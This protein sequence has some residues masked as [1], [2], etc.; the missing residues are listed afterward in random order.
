MPEYSTIRQIIGTLIGH[1]LVD[2]TQ[3]DEQEWMETGVAYVML[4][5][6][7]G[8]TLKFYIDEEGFDY[9]HDVVGLETD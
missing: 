2:I 6:D 7:D 4:M 8:R 1:K 9:D 3:H 5:F